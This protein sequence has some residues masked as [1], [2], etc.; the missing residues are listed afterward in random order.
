MWVH[1][2][3]VYRG[4]ALLRLATAD[5]RGHTREGGAAGGVAAARLAPLLKIV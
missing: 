2:R 5:H 1:V 3:S 4:G